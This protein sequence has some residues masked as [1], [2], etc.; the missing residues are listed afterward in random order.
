[1]GLLELEGVELVPLAVEDGA[2]LAGVEG[3]NSRVQ[4]EEWMSGEL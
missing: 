2:A 1:M 3:G 4:S